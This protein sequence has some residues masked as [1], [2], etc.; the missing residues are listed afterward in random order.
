MRTEKGTRDKDNF[1]FLI[2]NFE[3][4]TKGKGSRFKDK[5]TRIKIKKQRT[6]K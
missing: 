6:M 2:L 1:E 5:G 4:T 3:L